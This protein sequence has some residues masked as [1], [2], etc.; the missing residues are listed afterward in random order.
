MFVYYTINFRK[1]PY[2]F[3]T[4]Y[5]LRSYCIPN[6]AKIMSLSHPSINKKDYIPFVS[7]ECARQ[8]RQPSTALHFPN[9]HSM[10]NSVLLT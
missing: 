2:L 5:A 7:V 10:K 3:E 1:S 6:F 9:L 4:R 8:W